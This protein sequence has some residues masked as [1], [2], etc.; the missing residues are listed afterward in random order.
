MTRLSSVLVSHFLLD[1]QEAHQ[2]TVAGLAADD[3]FYTLQNHS[4]HSLNVTNMLGSLGATIYSTND[5]DEERTD[6]CV[7]ASELEG[8]S[9][10]NAY[11]SSRNT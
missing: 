4:A 5:E 1:L 10:S 6:C 7:A 2:R 8:V 11:D 3:S 9:P